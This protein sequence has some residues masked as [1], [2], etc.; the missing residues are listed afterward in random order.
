MFKCHS[1]DINSFTSI[2]Y[3]CSYSNNAKRGGSPLL[4]VATEQGVVYILDTRKR[5]DWDCEPQRISFQPFANGIFDVHWSPDDTLLATASADRTVH[6]SSLESTGVKTIR[7]L[8]G[9]KGTVKCVSWDPSRNGDILCSGGRDGGIC[10]WDLRVG[11][12]IQSPE[13]VERGSCSPVIVIPRAHDSKEQL[14]KSRPRK[15]KL[16]PATL[17]SITSL[18]FSPTEP[19][20]LISSGSTDGILRYWDLRLPILTGDSTR[21]K[22]A[23]KTKISPLITSTDPTTYQNTRRSRGISSLSLG[24]GPSAYS[25]FALAN[26]SRVHTFN[27]RTLEPLSGWTFSKAKDQAQETILDNWSYGHDEMRTNSFY[28]RAAT[29][30]CG[31]W[32]ASGGAEKGSVFLFDISGGA[33]SRFRSTSDDMG[34][35]GTRRAVQLRG[36][37]GEVGAVDW[38]QGMLASCAD[39]GTV[40]IWRQD[41]EV[42]RRC[43]ENAESMR[44]DW[45]WSTNA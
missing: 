15:G 3:A 21:S 41:I 28:V 17:R 10:V 13:D 31:S 42:Y 29:S 7:Q 26:D 25:L 19:L 43:Q 4:S 20:G 2:P 6:I 11:K 44:W 14:T 30:P 33:E 16:P 35:D 39:D 22:K 45:S 5:E 40:R 37:T 9:H 8:H 27:Q 36:Q 32:L 12:D 24:S 34:D 18:V 1:V 23:A 38:A